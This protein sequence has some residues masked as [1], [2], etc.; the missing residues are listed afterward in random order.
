M[1]TQP[2][3]ST[4]RSEHAMDIAAELRAWLA[5]QSDEVRSRAEQIYL[6]HLASGVLAR[7]YVLVLGTRR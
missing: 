5:E 7:L 4:M 1:A 2:S 6:D 3:D